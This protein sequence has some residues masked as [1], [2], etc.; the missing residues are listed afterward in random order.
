VNG[1]SAAAALKARLLQRV[2]R[3]VDELSFG[4]PVRSSEVVWSLM[5]EPGVADVNDARLVRHP[6]TFESV[7]FEVD[8]LDPSVQ[9]LG[10]G[11]NVELQ[12]NQ[13][14]RFVDDPGRLWIL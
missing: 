12:V 1:S 2:A 9:E 3:Y 5:N 13:I 6:P 11:A 14:A 10:C 8:Q 7:D 4:E